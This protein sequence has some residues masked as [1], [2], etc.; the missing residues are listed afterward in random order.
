MEIYT[1]NDVSGYYP[2]VSYRD[3]LIELDDDA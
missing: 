3:S 2:T 1:V